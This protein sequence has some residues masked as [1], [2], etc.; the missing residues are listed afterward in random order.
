MTRAPLPFRQVDVFPGSPRGGN[1]VAVVLDAEGVDD[2][3]MRSFARWTNL[4]ETTFVLPPTDPGADYRLR[5][6]TPSAELPFAGHPT[7][8]SAHAW[9]EHTGSAEDRLVQQCGVGLVGLRRT[10]DGWAL[11]APPLIRSGPATEDE[12]ASIAAGLGLPPT[13]IVA[14]EWVDNGPGWVVAVLRDAEAVLAVDTDLAAMAVPTGV[15]GPHAAGGPAD[16][17]VR[18]F[19]PDLGVD[20]DPVTGSL[21][22]GIGTWFFGSGRAS[23]SYTVR[24]GTRIGANGLVRVSDEPDGVWVAGATTTVLSGTV[25]L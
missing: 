2:G 4:S 18:A 9:A 3:T 25:A 19:V 1:P 21:N 20:E 8:G 23:G 12:V 15:V 16:F 7:L 24:Q 11:A 6:F 10:D 14:A 13:E 5:I 22:A 17:E